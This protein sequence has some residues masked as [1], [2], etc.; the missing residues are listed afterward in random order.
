[1][2]LQI[3]LSSYPYLPILNTNTTFISPLKLVS[4]C[5]FLS[6]SYLLP[7]LHYICPGKFPVIYTFT[8]VFSVVSDITG[9]WWATCWTNG[10]DRWRQ[11]VDG[12]GYTGEA[13]W[14][15]RV[16]PWHTYLLGHLEPDI[17]AELE[18]LTHLLWGRRD[19]GNFV[20]GSWV[21]QLFEPLYKLIVSW[22]LQAWNAKQKSQMTHLSGVLCACVQDMFS[23]KLRLTCQLTWVSG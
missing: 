7:T 1:M 20:N 15:T 9:I 22:V 18:H 17:G 6:V 8:I 3:T 16:W 23:D 11:R 2:A 4:I 19:Q 13:A 12:G 5:K 10:A 14:R 21:L